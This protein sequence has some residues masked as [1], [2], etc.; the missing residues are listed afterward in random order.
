MTFCQID[1]SNTIETTSHTWD[2]IGTIQAWLPDSYRNNLE[3]VTVRLPIQEYI[4]KP[5]GQRE[6]LFSYYKT[7]WSLVPIS[8]PDQDKPQ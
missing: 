4:L 8:L 1:A 7:V 2:Q 3:V 5:T 6:I